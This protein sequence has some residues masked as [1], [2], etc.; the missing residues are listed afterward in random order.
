MNIQNFNTTP[1]KAFIWSLMSDKGIFKS[2]DNKYENTIQSYFEK[3]MNILYRDK[4]EVDTLITLNKRII[5]IM[6][7]EIRQ[8]YT[9]VK[10]QPLYTTQ[11]IKLNKQNIFNEQLNNKQ[12]E[13]VQLIN[14]Q[15]P[16]PIDFSRKKN[17][18]DENFDIDRLLAETISKRENLVIKINDT[19][20]NKANEWINNSRIVS[21]SIVSPS[22]VSPSIVSPSIVSPSIV[23]PS[24]V[25]PSIV[26]PSIVSPSIVSPSI[27][28]NQINNRGNLQIG[29]E[30]ALSYEQIKKEKKNV[31]F[32]EQVD[33]SFE[34]VRNDNEPYEKL[35]LQHIQMQINELNEKVNKIINML[36]TK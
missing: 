35:N 17:D 13:F 21:P 34:E 36:S 28:P 26:S 20:K 3:N 16:S 23:S 6:I 2:V 9:L 7:S 33:I 19:E 10:E 31:S 18:D 14:T 4:R 25:S 5:D 29:S 1:N 11:D 30:I 8:N 15:I 12:N 32:N 22:I 24:I 27:V